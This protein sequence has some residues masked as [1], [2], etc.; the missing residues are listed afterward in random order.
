MLVI[1][2]IV[3]SGFDLA[4][5]GRGNLNVDGSS[6][7][8]THRQSWGLEEDNRDRYHDQETGDRDFRSAYDTPFCAGADLA[9]GRE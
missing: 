3:L 4:R 5:T 9:P 2:L 7:H 6:Q 8:T 1:V